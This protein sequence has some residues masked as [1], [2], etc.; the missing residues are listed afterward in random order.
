M[1]PVSALFPAVRLTFS[2]A[3][4]LSTS[5]RALVYA[6]AQGPSPVPCAVFQRQQI[7]VSCSSIPSVTYAMDKR[8]VI[9]RRSR[10]HS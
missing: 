5:D 6:S 2:S 10:N 7:H 3:V 1:H 9:V 8:E 4:N